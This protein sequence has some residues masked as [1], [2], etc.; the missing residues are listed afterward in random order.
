MK[1]LKAFDFSYFQSKNH[2]E[3]DGTQNWLVFQPMHRYF[4]LASDNPSIILSWK[5][6][7]LSDERIK[8]TAT[9]N[10]I[11]NP[12]QNYI[13]TKARVRFSRDCL[14]QNKNYI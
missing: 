9:S 1:Q 12:S 4:K 14:K 2:F 7:E 11:L 10:K 13:G 5:Y 6:K 3:D 8:S